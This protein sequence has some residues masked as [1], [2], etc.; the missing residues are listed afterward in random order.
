MSGPV[1]PPSPASGVSERRAEQRRADERRKRDRRAEH[2]ALALLADE[3]QQ[4]GGSADTPRAAPHG[5][6]TPA[7]AAAFSAQVM[8]QDGQKRGLK[9]GEPVLDAARRSYL[10]T[11]Y[12]G[13]RDRRPRAGVVKKTEI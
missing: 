11:E 8:G 3:A 10:G 12:A 1:K 13:T 4:E 9:G 7:G 5:G 2:R 6:A